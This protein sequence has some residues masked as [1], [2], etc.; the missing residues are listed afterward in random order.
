MWRIMSSSAAL[1][2]MLNMRGHTQQACCNLCLYLREHV[3]IS[4]FPDVAS[5]EQDGA[6]VGGGV[7]PVE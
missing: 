5:W 7:T 1:V 2:N 3:L 4:R 6:S